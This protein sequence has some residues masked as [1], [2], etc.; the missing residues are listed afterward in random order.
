MDNVANLG[1]AVHRDPSNR[2]IGQSGCYVLN[3]SIRHLLEMGNKESAKVNLLNSCK[4]SKKA[5]KE[6]NSIPVQ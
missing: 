5:N 1:S 2:N 3:R 6:G 4:T